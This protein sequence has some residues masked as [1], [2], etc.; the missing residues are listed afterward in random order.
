[1]AINFEST[2]T[3]ADFK[4]P[5]LDKSE[6]SLMRELRGEADLH[7]EGLRASLFSKLVALFIGGR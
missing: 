1:M 6:E 7:V 5:L 4:R 2:M 3:E